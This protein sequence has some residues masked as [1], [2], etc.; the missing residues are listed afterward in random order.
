MIRIEVPF[1]PYLLGD[2]AGFLIRTI[3]VKQRNEPRLNPQ[4]HEA[5]SSPA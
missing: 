3:L 5:S 4:P 1:T 2:G